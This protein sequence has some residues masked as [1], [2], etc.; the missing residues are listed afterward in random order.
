LWKAAAVSDQSNQPK[1]DQPP[2]DD[3]LLLDAFVAKQNSKPGPLFGKVLIESDHFAGGANGVPYVYRHGVYVPASIHVKKRIQAMAGDGWSRHIQTEVESWLVANAPPL[4]LDALGPRR[5]N[6]RNGILT[7]AG[8]RGWRLKPHDPEFRTPVQYPVTY[9]RSA[10]CPDYDSFLASS[11]PD[12]L[13]RRLADEWMGFNLTPD[14]SFHKAL[15]TT[16]ESGSGKSVFLEVLTG[17]LGKDNVSSLALVELT[18]DRFGGA[19]LYGKAANICTDIESA[20]LRSTG[21]FKRLVSGETFRAQRKNR[22]PFDFRNTAKFSFSANEIPASRDTTS[23]FF[24]RWLVIIFPLKFRDTPRDKKGLHVLIA[25][26][27]HEMSGVLNRALDGLTRLR[28]QGNFTGSASTEEARQLFRER[29]DGFSAW[30]VELNPDDLAVGKVPG[31][32]RR[33]EWY[34]VYRLWCVETGHQRLSSTKFY[35]RAR[36]WGSELDMTI[37]VTKSRGYEF[38]TLE[39]QG[40]VEGS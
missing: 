34:G 29:A 18:R 35:E 7:W 16:G 12:E 20:E 31:R 38:F 40:V 39:R 22:D 3:Q 24:E 26:N 6:V 17:L 19:D 33:E 9:D 8:G 11:L 30:I 23:A 14:Y 36:K 32:R 10:V 1:D 28:R 25:S 21:A 15:M 5:I 4:E 13:V 37:A 27:P 2:S